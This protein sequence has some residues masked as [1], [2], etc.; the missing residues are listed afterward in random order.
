[1]QHCV[2]MVVSS[3]SH[4]RGQPVILMINSTQVTQHGLCRRLCWRLF[5]LNDTEYQTALTGYQLHLGE[6]SCA[7]QVVILTVHT[8]ISNNVITIIFIISCLV[9]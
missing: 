2:K 8:Q 6:L 4:E 9:G 1:M 7:L 3:I 5:F